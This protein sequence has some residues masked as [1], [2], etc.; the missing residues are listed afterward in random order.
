MKLQA[1]LSYICFELSRSCENCSLA[2]LWKI[3][4][5]LKISLFFVNVAVHTIFKYTDYSRHYFV[6]KSCHGYFLFKKLLMKEDIYIRV[7]CFYYYALSNSLYLIFHLLPSD[8]KI[9]NQVFHPWNILKTRP[10][11]ISFRLSY[12]T[13]F[14]I[15]HFLVRIVVF[16]LLQ[17]R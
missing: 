17:R 9:T 13:I 5:V 15:I 6:I 12:P 16:F 7:N 10:S 3:I 14:S 2:A 1:V 4:D 11:Q 8:S